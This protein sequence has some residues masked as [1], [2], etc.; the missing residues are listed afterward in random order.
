[1]AWHYCKFKCVI[2]CNHSNLIPKFEALFI[3]LKRQTSNKSIPVQ[4]CQ[5]E[6]D[7]L[8]IY[9]QFPRDMTPVHE[10]IYRLLY[11]TIIQVAEVHLRSFLVVVKNLLILFHCHLKSIYWLKASQIIWFQRSV[12]KST[13]TRSC[14][15]HCNT[16]LLMSLQPSE[17]GYGV[18]GKVV[19]SSKRM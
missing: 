5:P 8:I 17:M 9:L 12:D 7:V 13:S 19:S 15:Y 18:L 16:Q 10:F 3:Y 6:I 14:W 1:M 11:P 2:Q 4:V